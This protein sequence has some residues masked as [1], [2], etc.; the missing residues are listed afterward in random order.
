M[1]VR[2]NAWSMRDSALDF[3]AEDLVPEFSING[4]D[5]MPGILIN[6]F[7]PGWTAA[8][9]VDDFVSR[10]R[11]PMDATLVRLK[12]LTSNGHDGNTQIDAII[13]SRAM[14][15]SIP[16]PGTLMLLAVGGAMLGYRRG[17]LPAVSA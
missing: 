15:G 10:W 9:L 12:A 17:G 3:G 16:E 6:V 13:A 5:W 7:L 2:N 1:D 14:P 4:V 8:S 11:S